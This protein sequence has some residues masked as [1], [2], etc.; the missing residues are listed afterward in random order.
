MKFRNEGKKRLVRIGTSEEATWVPVKHGQEVDLPEEIGRHH[1]FKPVAFKSDIHNKKEVE[2]K[3]TDNYTPDD[4]FYKELVNI[5]GI[6]KSTAKDIVNW[7]TKEK[8]IEVI[9]AGGT[10]PF[11]DDVETKLKKKFG[12]NK[13]G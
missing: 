4:L 8:L 10:L 9:E 7:G 5:K 11:R 13:N 6:G 1:G 2:T 12:G 3:I